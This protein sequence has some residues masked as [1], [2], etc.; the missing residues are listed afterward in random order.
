VR[1]ADTIIPGISRACRDLQRR[2][3]G[4]PAHDL[5]SLHRRGHNLD[6]VLAHRRLP[7]DGNGWSIVRRVKSASVVRHF[8]RR[9]RE[10]GSP[11]RAE[12]AK[13]YM[14]SALR[15]HGVDAAQLRAECVSF[16]SAHPDMERDEL[17]AYATA[18][19]ATD[20][21]DLRSAA[22]VLLERRW[23]LLQASDASWLVE[24]ARL[25]V[26]LSRG[27]DYAT[28]SEDHAGE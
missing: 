7:D 22:I 13:A 19:F 9:F 25:L 20:A 16:C 12:G 1:I 10:L 3:I 27:R 8:D 17:I 21:F 14:K 18:L 26:G 2:S 28:R 11:R 5:R 23:K 15:F 24:L 4:A 6:V